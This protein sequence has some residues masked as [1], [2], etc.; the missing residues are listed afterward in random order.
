MRENKT[1]IENLEHKSKPYQSKYDINWEYN[2]TQIM[3]TKWYLWP[4]PIMPAFS[5]P[6]GEG[7]YFEKNV[8]S[9]EDEGD[10]ED[11]E[12]NNQGNERTP[13]N[14][15]RNDNQGSGG[16]Q[17]SQQTVPVGRVQNYNYRPAS[18]KTGQEVVQTTKQ[19]DRMT[20]HN[21]KANKWENLNNIVKA[22]NA[23]QVYKSSTSDE[24]NVPV[25]IQPGNDK[26]TNQIDQRT[27][28]D[29]KTQYYNKTTNL[30]VENIDKRRLANER[31]D[32]KSSTGQLIK[33]TRVSEGPEGAASAGRKTG[34]ISPSVKSKAR[35]KKSTGRPS[36]TKRTTNTAKRGPSGYR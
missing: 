6:K 31:I 28:E 11:K 24:N 3:G 18:I 29:M 14:L 35:P 10:E 13:V 21:E 23:G 9:D 36:T 8:D 27:Y 30:A 2:S 15:N 4:F 22:D 1:T 33:G 7:I 17:A 32:S 5:K 20:L 16:Q 12:Q 26:Y 25:A 19:G 34:Y